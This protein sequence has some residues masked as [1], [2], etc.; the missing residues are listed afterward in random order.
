MRK[1]ASLIILYLSTLIFSVPALAHEYENT[2]DHMLFSGYKEYGISVSVT[3][4]VDT[5]E[6]AKIYL[7]GYNNAGV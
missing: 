5:E 1:M 6:G 4:N 7:A 3:T 2:I